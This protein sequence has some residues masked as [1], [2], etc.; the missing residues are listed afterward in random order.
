MPILS[1][2]QYTGKEPK[3]DKKEA[4][5]SRILDSEYGIT[6]AEKWSS[7]QT[8]PARDLGERRAALVRQAV[9]LE[10]ARGLVGNRPLNQFI[11]P[12]YLAEWRQIT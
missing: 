3:S 12:N 6:V 11:T 10:A 2:Y 5:S 1:S 7:V 9:F 8:F 4:A